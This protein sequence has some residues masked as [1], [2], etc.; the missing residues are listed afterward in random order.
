[1]TQGVSLAEFLRTL[2]LHV[3]FEPLADRDLARAAQ[4]SRRV[5]QFNLNSR[6]RGETELRRLRQ[7][8]LCH[9][10]RVSDRFGD[11]G[12]V[13]VII[14]RAE[15]NA[16]IVETLLL[17]CRSLGKGVE[18]HIAN[19]ILRYSQDLDTVKFH[20]VPSH[21]NLPVQE[22]LTDIGCTLDADDCQ[23]VRK[24]VLSERLANQHGTF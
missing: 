5:T 1:M 21:R 4:L 20:F 3:T 19:F 18:S 2:R 23:T 13:G 10:V 17:S 16:L 14:F 15:Q 8:W 22:F 6:K 7:D 9:V 11:Y 12:L 24:E